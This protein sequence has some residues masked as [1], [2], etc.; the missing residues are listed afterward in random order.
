MTALSRRVL[1][2]WKVRGSSL[3][4]LFMRTQTP[5]VRFYPHDLITCH[6]RHL[7][8][9]S[10]GGQNVDV[11][12]GR[13][14]HKHRSTAVRAL[15]A[16]VGRTRCRFAFGRG[17]ET[18]RDTGGEKSHSLWSASP[19][20]GPGD[21]PALGQRD[22]ASPGGQPSSPATRAGGRAPV[23]LTAS[24]VPSLSPPPPPLTAACG[25]RAPARGLNTT[26]SAM[27]DQV[28]EIIPDVDFLKR[29][30]I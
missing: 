14:G 19:A 24:S 16:W 1:T 6:R 23:Q 15:L 26:A 12:T 2:W 21:C 4:P 10:L 11:G 20:P 22:P 27:E 25:L 30:F 17:R 9:P 28:Q 5:L 3:G 7:L 29:L 13:G 18:P 8:S